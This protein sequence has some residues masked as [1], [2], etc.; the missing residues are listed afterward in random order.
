MERYETRQTL[1]LLLVATHLCL[2]NIERHQRHH[3]RTTVPGNLE[4]TICS[5]TGFDALRLGE[6]V[7]LNGDAQKNYSICWTTLLM[8]VLSTD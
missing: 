6:A 3:R 7:I 5:W 1:S 2:E 8:G 4:V